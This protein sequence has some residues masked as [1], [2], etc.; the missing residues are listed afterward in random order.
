MDQLIEIFYSDPN[1][2]GF[3]NNNVNSTLYSIIYKDGTISVQEDAETALDVYLLGGSSGLIV[4]F[5][6]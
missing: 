5:T 2:E 6:R 4:A 1:I 3:Q